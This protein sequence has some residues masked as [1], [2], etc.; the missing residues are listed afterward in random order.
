[1]LRSSNL[2]QL[3]VARNIEEY[4]ALAIALATR[5]SARRKLASRSSTPL[6]PT[7]PPRIHLAFTVP[8]TYPLFVVLAD[9]L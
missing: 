7:H 9:L 8:S 3:L 6:L 5:A 2:E 1:M 4:T